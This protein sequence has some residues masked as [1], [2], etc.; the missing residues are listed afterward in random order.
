MRIR[1]IV[2]SLVLLS[3]LPGLNQLFAEEIIGEIVYLEDEIEITR[4]SVALDYVDIGTTIENFDLLTTGEY[5]LAEVALTTEGSPDATIKVSPNTTFYF[6]LNQLKQGN[7]TTLGMISGS[8]SMKVRKMSRSQAFEVRTESA[9]MGVRGTS[10]TVTTTVAGDLL[11]TCDEGRVSCYD[12]DTELFAVPG[13]AVEK[14]AGE[15]FRAIPVAVSDLRTFKDN[16]YAERLS[17]FKSNALKALRGYVVRYLTLVENFNQAYNRLYRNKE[18]ISKWF[19]QD[20]NGTMG[21]TMENMREKKKL[22]GDLL[23]LRRVLFIFERVYFRLQELKSY[24]DQGYGRGTIKAGLTAD[25]FFR[26]FERDKDELSRKMARI[27]YITKLY[28][29]RNN[30]SFPT[31]AFSTDESS[32]SFL[33]SDFSF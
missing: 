9:T 25:A 27:R 18:I 29:I 31:D 10:F 12:E 5:G 26:R 33:N 19:R 22:I 15:I 11:I 30:G 20:S 4:N 24:Y 6:E 23:R 1:E 8:V 13:K 21:S 3:C 2:M 32:E 14:R 16:W 28:S 17:V 7:K